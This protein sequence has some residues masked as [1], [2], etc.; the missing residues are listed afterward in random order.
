MTGLDDEARTLARLQAVARGRPLVMRPAADVAPRP[1]AGWLALATMPADGRIWAGT[2][3]L[4]SGEVRDLTVLE[5]RNAAVER[6]GLGRLVGFLDD[7]TAPHRGEEGGDYPQLVV[8]D[9]ETTRALQLLRQRFR[10]DPDPVLRRL[11]WQV[12]F[13]L[14]SAKLDGAD[15]YLDLR[16]LLVE[17]VAWPLAPAEERDLGRLLAAAETDPDVRGQLAAARTCVPD[18]VADTLSDRLIDRSRAIQR[19][20]LA[21]WQERHEMDILAALRTHAAALLDL[22][23]RAL[24]LWQALGLRLLDSAQS[25][26][27]T[28]DYAYR[29]RLWRQE[30]P[31]FAPARPGSALAA[32]TLL[33]REASVARRAHHLQHADDGAFAEAVLAGEAARA[34][35]VERA[36]SRLLRVQIAQP[37][38]KL[39]HGDTLD[40]RGL[41]NTQVVLAEIGDGPGLYALRVESGVRRLAALHPGD[42]LG[43]IRSYDEGLARKRHRCLRLWREQ[44]DRPAAHRAS[45]PA[46]ADPVAWYRA[47][48]APPQP[49]NTAGEVT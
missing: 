32:H 48:I 41:R 3:R 44:A 31:P 6:E 14:D 29:R 4:P 40:V 28:A 20:T 33:R 12:G 13:F 15:A 24:A 47:H 43:L 18:D 11:A 37:N 17:H 27:L 1:E 30:P 8:P 22:L 38:L 10:A 7:L 19:G 35:L 2:A 23:D 39:R 26:A 25:G 34:T 16:A 36:T 49:G 21:A 5:P 42:T 45:H 46:A 9:G